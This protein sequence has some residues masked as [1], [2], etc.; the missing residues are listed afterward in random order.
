MAAIFERYAVQRYEGEYCA[1]RFEDADSWDDFL[2]FGDDMWSVLGCGFAYYPI[3]RAMYDHLLA[4]NIADN[5]GK[6]W[7][8]DEDGVKCWSVSI[9]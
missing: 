6:E 7:E 9:G 4:E 3:N 8:Y 1:Y 5:G 2:S